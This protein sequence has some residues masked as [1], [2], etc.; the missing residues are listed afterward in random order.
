MKLKL[1][2][3]KKQ[4]NIH[5]NE[6]KEKYEKNSPPENRRDKQSFSMVKEETTPIYHMLDRWETMGLEAVKKREI[7]VHPHQI[8]S[9]KENMELL[10]MHS[11][12]IDARKKRYMEL[13]KSVKYIFDQMVRE[14]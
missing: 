10:L 4:L 5:L 6:L 12:Y 7:N 11:Y 14:L 1:K 9:T 8:S 13:N 3:L 2:A